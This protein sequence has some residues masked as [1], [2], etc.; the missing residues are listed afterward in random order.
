M[1]QLCFICRST[2]DTSPLLPSVIWQQNIMKYRQK[3]S[4]STAMPPTS[5]SSTMDKHNKTGDITFRVSLIYMH[6][7]YIYMYNC[8]YKTLPS[9]YIIKKCYLNCLY[10]IFLFNVM[11]LIFS[12]LVKFMLLFVLNCLLDFFFCIVLSPIFK[13][14]KILK[15]LLMNIN[16][17]KEY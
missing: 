11:S 8:S 13:W 5:T 12:D 6:I 1:T 9:F 2:S 15:R 14:R 7:P 17:Q 10:L 4:V 16:I 3:C